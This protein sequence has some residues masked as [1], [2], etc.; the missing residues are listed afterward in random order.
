M[1][2]Q[3]R[4]VGFRGGVPEK[5][6]WSELSYVLPVRPEDRRNCRGVLIIVV[7]F[8]FALLGLA[9]LSY[10]LSPMIAKI[11]GLSERLPI[12]IT[13]IILLTWFL[14]GYFFVYIP[15]WIFTRRLRTRSELLF[16]PGQESVFVS[17]EDP[18]TYDR[19]KLATEDYGL[20]QTSPG[21][22]QIEMTG[23]RA[24]FAAESLT[25][26]LVYAHKNAVGV[27]LSYE[28]DFYPWSVAITP[29]G[30]SYNI[31]KEAKHKERAQ[32]LKNRL[33]EAGV[34]ARTMP[35]TMRDE[36]VQETAAVKDEYDEIP[37]A[38][39]LEEAITDDRGG[40]ADLLEHRYQEIVQEIRSQEKSRKGWI[41]SLG[42]LAITLL[43]FVQLGYMRWGLEFIAILLVVVAIHEAGHF[44]GMKIFGYKNIQMFFIPLA[45]AAVSGTSRDVAA[46]KKAI[47]TLLGPLPGLV[48]GLILAI[49]CAFAGESI[50]ARLA[51]MFLL[52]NLLN[53]LPIFPLDGG[54][55]LHEVVFSRSRYVEAVMNVL[56][57][58]V[59]LIAGFALED[60]VLRILGFLNLFT[61]A[62]KFKL[63]GAA[64]KIRTELLQS[65]SELLEQSGEGDII[66]ESV[67]KQ[68]IIWMQ[69]NIAGS[70]KPKA[71]ATMA[72]GLWERIRILPPRAGA[73]AGLLVLYLSGYIL[74]LVGFFFVGMTYWEENRFKSEIVTVF[75]PNG[76]VGYVERS[77][78]KGELLSETGLT[79]DQKYYHGA[80]IQ[81]YNFVPYEDG[82]WENGRKV[83]TWKIRDPNGLEIQEIQYEAGRPILFRSLTEGRWEETAWEDFSREDRDFYIEDAEIRYGPGTEY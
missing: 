53:L 33:V 79:E 72:L 10:F 60:W 18:F 40:N 25:A 7:T 14:T 3:N 75:D 43:V 64:C 5:V 63:A 83:G 42:I 67:L 29:S 61:I 66:P 27:R 39:L 59:L 81:Y 49:V 78:L 35:A 71:V 47:V 55:F 65:N 20:I 6:V 51:G 54:R 11:L 58:A 19:Q 30:M 9:T 28:H 26:S 69:R 57:A 24:Q 62:H 15:K 31:F 23:H 32:Q 48:I 12:M 41:K 34:R 38:V 4:H 17:I 68:M 1:G 8:F 76:V 82:V 74:S 50:F 70:M 77:Y 80:S 73:T 13:G 44:V 36:P 16:E 21:L 2:D 46:W 45:G 52:V 56:A 37:T 22:V